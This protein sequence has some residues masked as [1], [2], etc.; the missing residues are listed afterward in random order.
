MVL[1]NCPVGTT[2]VRY[3]PR[4]LTMAQYTSD[5]DITLTRH[6]TLHIN[7]CYRGPVSRHDLPK[8]QPQPA[9]CSRQT[10]S[11]SALYHRHGP[12]LFSA[13]PPMPEQL[14]S[15][16]LRPDQVRSKW[17]A[18]RVPGEDPFAV[19]TQPG[20]GCPLPA[21]DHAVNCAVENYKQQLRLLERQNKIRLQRARQEQDSRA[22]DTGPRNNPQTYQLPQA[23][24]CV[25]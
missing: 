7:I 20:C 16:R 2:V 3:H 6:S 19:R 24:S 25:S 13:G 17:A 22:S 5:N 10:P 18:H 15:V 11:S 4:L 9:W 12:S 1:L 23:R 14:D 21:A 8:T